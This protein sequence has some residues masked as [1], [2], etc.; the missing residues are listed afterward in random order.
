ML[1]LSECD[2]KISLE[3]YTVRYHRPIILCRRKVYRFQSYS[4]V[5]RVGL[6]VHSH[7]IGFWGG[8]GH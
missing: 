6:H 7:K 1:G 5:T 2:S 3:V 8:G 4:L